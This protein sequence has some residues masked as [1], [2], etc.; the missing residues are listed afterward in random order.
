MT[1]AKEGDS[2]FCCVLLCLSGLFSGLTLGLMSLTVSDLEIYIQ[3]EKPDEDAKDYQ[4]RVDEALNAQKILPMRQR[5][6]LLLCTLLLGNTLVNALI[7]ILSANFTSGAVGAAVSTFFIV[8]FGEITPQSVCSRYGLYIGAKTIGVVKVFMFLFPVA[9][10]ISRVLDCILGE[11]MGMAYDKQELAQ[12]VD[13]QEKNT[14]SNADAS[15]TNLLKGALAFGQKTVKDIMTTRYAKAGDNPGTWML[16]IS[17]KLDFD[18]M[19]VIY[20]TG[21]TRIPICDGNEADPQ[22]P[23]VGLLLT[24]DLMLVTDAPASMSTERP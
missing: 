24:K 4:E 3:S 18:T 22:S 1:G 17:K 6:N 13:Q 10:P 11:D 12:L 14:E 7:A 8:I 2:V 5:G 23:I 9:Y 19:L 20:K 21:Y 16:D 15:T